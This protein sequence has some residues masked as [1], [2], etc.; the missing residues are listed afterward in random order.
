MYQNSKSF[1]KTLISTLKCSVAVTQ[2]EILVKQENKQEK[3]I[4]RHKESN[5]F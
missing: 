4:N 3:Q 5:L 2:N 1:F